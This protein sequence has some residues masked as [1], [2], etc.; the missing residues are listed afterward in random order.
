VVRQAFALLE[1]VSFFTAHRGA[2]ARARVVRRGTPARDAAG[3]VH[4]DMRGGFVA[5]EVIGWEELVAAGGYAGARERALLRTEGRDYEI[6]D[7][8]VVSFRFSPA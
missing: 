4:E 5:A 1:L 2:E 3:S 6:R 7:G 8:E